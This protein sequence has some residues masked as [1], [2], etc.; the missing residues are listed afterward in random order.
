VSFTKFSYN[1][2]VYFTTYYSSFKIIYGFNPLD[3]FP[4]PINKKVSLDGNRKTHVIKALY[5]NVR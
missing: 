5:E 4:L 1:N 2:N 3:L